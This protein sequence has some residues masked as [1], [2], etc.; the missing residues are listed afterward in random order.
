MGMDRG[1]LA[2]ASSTTTP[3]GI[4]M[5]ELERDLPD[6]QMPTTPATLP[7]LAIVGAGRA[8]SAIHRAAQGA[9]LE[10][11]LAGRD[12]ARAACEAAEMAL[13]CVPDSEIERAAGVAAGCVPPLLFVGHTSGAI[14]LDA[15]DAARTR[16]A[17][18]FG[19][20]PLQTL[21]DGD[22]PVA[23]SACAVS[24]SDAEAVAL[25]LRL[26]HALGMA[27]F[28]IQEHQRAAYHAAAAMASNFLVALEES[29]S[30]L[31]EAAGVDSARELLGPLVL[32]TAANWTERGGGALTGPIA[33]GDEET[34][35][36]HREAIARTAPELLALSDE[37]AARTRTLAQGVER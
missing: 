29:A 31:L 28:V 11:T 22:S 2:Q 5:R 30:A 13:L 14:G 25:A 27:P 23:G 33:R 35:A 32:R 21:P 4:S 20:H 10:A 3:S 12:D 7:A 6:R 26:A 15:L 8:G 36:R 1:R 37:L 19:L 24:G 34:V 18:T 17:R 16:G 9:G